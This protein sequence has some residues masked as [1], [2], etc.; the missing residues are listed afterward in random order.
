MISIWR[1]PDRDK[2]GHIESWTY[3]SYHM[4]DC[5]NGKNIVKLFRPS[6]QEINAILILDERCRFV[7]E[8]NLWF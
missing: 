3:S 2:I 4:T 1:V 7:I 8:T 6:T 5:D